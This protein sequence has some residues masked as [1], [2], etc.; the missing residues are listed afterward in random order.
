[1]IGFAAF[2]RGTKG[3]G[4]TQLP[5]EAELL[6]VFSGESDH[7]HDRPLYEVIVLEAR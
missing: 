4:S 5:E 6:R 2:I 1:L 3:N 7:Y